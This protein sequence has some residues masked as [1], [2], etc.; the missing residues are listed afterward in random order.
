MNK[1]RYPDPQQHFEQ[2]MQSAAQRYVDGLNRAGLP[3]SERLTRAVARRAWHHA[4]ESY[5]Q[6]AQAVRDHNISVIM[7]DHNRRMNEI[8]LRGHRIRLWTCPPIA[9][10]FGVLAWYNFQSH[11]PDGFTVGIICAVFA[12]A[13][14]SMLILGAFFDRPR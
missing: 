1:R 8:K 2:H 5:I 11:L 6:E 7:Q 9:L 4:R 14:L 10:V 3:P 13:F 12:L